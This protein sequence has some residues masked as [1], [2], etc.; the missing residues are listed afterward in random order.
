MDWIWEYVVRGS[1]GAL[2][3]FNTLWESAGAMATF[4]MNAFALGAVAAMNEVIHLFTS[5]LPITISWFADNW[6]SILR[7]AANLTTTIF[8]NMIYNAGVFMA[9]LKRLLSGGSADFQFRGIADGFQATM[10]D[11]PKYAER[12]PSEL[13]GKLQDAMDKAT[14][15]MNQSWARNAAAATGAIED[16]LDSGKSKLPTK[17]R[18]KLGDGTGHDLMSSS[19]EEEGQTK[20]KLKS[21]KA[22]KDSQGQTE[23]LESAYRRVQEAASGVVTETEKLQALK[24]NTEALKGSEVS[25]V[26]RSQSAMTKQTNDSISET[27]AGILVA[28]SATA[29]ATRQTADAIPVLTAAVSSMKTGLA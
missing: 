22:S 21:E 19:E 17:P 4:A 3:V 12:V 8:D 13:E 16:I 7:D 10:R 14:K 15:T 24:E 2:A 25:E 6:V 27:L 1:Q 29:V 26:V 28:T 9:G 5:T 18:A 23:D 11:L 20:D